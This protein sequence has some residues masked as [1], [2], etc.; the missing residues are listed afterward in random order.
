MANPLMTLIRGFPGKPSHPPLTDV[1]IGAYTVGVAMLVL[2][3]FGVEEEQMAHGALLAI[4]GGLAVS[5]PTALTGLLDWL[6]IEKETP[7]RTIATVHLVT[8]LLATAAFAVTFATHLDGYDEGS[9]EGYVAVLGLI[10]EGLLTAGGYLGGTL[11]F[12]YGIRVL[13][14]RDVPVGDAL[15]PWHGRDGGDSHASTDRPPAAIDTRPA[16]KGRSETPE[17]ARRRIWGG[18]D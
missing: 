15:I 1:A 10:A 7:R 8:M 9:V 11:V 4:G 6:Q 5:L 16:T 2:G 17:E 12:V 18:G 14:R 13:G 3:V